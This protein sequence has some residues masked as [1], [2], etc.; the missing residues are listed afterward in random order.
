GLG[1]KNSEKKP[2]SRNTGLGTRSRHDLGVLS[3]GEATYNPNYV[4]CV[5]IDSRDDLWA[6][7]WGGGLSH[8]DGVEW[9]NYTAEDGLAGDIVYSMALESNGVLWVG[10]NG[11]LS[12]FDG[13][14]WE[15]Y[16]HREGLSDLN[17]YAVVV[18]PEGEVWAGTKGAVVRLG[19]TKGDG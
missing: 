8:F 16:G 17:V 18:T 14:N 19:K 6:G 13:T 4:F 10:T 12:R 3:G 5:L 9:T 2:F 7:T 11:G 15:N 1:E